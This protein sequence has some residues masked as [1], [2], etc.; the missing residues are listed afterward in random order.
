MTDAELLAASKLSQVD[1]DDQLT[2][3]EQVE[4]LTFERDKLRAELD[5]FGAALD[6]AVEDRNAAVAPA[7]TVRTSVPFWRA[8]ASSR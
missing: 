6:R 4:V 5:E 7:R 3:W 1:R 2:A 8:S